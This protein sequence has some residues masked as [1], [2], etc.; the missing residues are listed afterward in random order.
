MLQISENSE[1]HLP[2][3]IARATETPAETTVIFPSRQYWLT[4]HLFEF[5]SGFFNVRLSKIN[6]KLCIG[7]LNEKNKFKSIHFQNSHKLTKQTNFP[8]PKGQITVIPANPIFFS[9]P[10][11]EHIT[12]NHLVMFQSWVVSESETS[13]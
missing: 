6:F 4:C 1:C 13:Q 8:L 12:Q 5:K 3:P 2:V 10:N 9:F 11:Q 7:A